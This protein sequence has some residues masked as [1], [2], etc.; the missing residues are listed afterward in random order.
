MSTNSLAPRRTQRPAIGPGVW[1]AATL[2]AM[3]VLFIVIAG[4]VQ[5]GPDSTPVTGTTR[6]EGALH[7]QVLPRGGRVD[8]ADRAARA[9]LG[10]A[11]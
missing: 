3:F 6:A 5:V 4:A 1:L 9:G 8:L 2:A 11:R 10:D 7:G